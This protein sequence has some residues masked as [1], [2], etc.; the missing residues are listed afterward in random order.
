MELLSKAQIKL[1][2]S[3]Q[4]KKYRL[5]YDKFIVEGPK[6]CKEL[7][8]EQQNIVECVYVSSTDYQSILINALGEERICIITPQQMKAISQMTTPPGVLALCRIPKTHEPP[9]DVSGEKLFYLEGIR[10]PGNL[11][12][13]L[14][15]ADWFGMPWVFMSPDCVDIY[16]HKVIQA[17]MGSAL[18]VKVCIIDIELLI[19]SLQIDLYACD[20]KGQ[21]YHAISPPSEGIL[22]LGNESKGVSDS[23]KQKVKALIS[24]PGDRSQGAESLN[25][26]SVAAIMGAWLHR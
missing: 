5:K 26:A 16:N 19:E 4:H 9:S 3:L 8:A 1:I 6:I 2:Q 15:I 13:I 11:G 14:R 18:R 24:I 7:L 12:T 23:V 22:V 25:V 21:N 17:S 20:M 10:D